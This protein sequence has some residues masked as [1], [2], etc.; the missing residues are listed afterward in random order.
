MLYY[1]IMNKKII[2]L[3]LVLVLFC[4]VLKRRNKEDF[5]INDFDNTVNTSVRVSGIPVFNGTKDMNSLKDM[6][7]SSNFNNLMEK[8][9]TYTVKDS[10]DQDA[11]WREYDGITTHNGNINLEPGIADGILTEK[12]GMIMKYIDDIN[13]LPQSSTEINFLS[14]DKT[15]TL[16][17]N[18]IDDLKEIVR[19]RDHEYKLYKLLFR[20]QYIPIECKDHKQRVDEQGNIVVDEDGEIV[21][22]PISTYDVMKDAVDINNF[23]L[24]DSSGKIRPNQIVTK[25]STDRVNYFGSVNGNTNALPR[26][27]IEVVD[28]FNSNENVKFHVALAVKE[29]YSNFA[30]GIDMDKKEAANIAILRCMYH[31][32]SIDDRGSAINTTNISITDKNHLLS[33]HP[34]LGSGLSA[35]EQNTVLDQSELENSFIQ[36]K[37]ESN[38]IGNKLLNEW[39]NLLEQDENGVMTWD[40]LNQSTLNGVRSLR[41]YFARLAL[42]EHMDEAADNEG[43]LRNRTELF[44]IDNE[45]VGLYH[46]F[47]YDDTTNTNCA[48]M[49]ELQNISTQCGNNNCFEAVVVGY[50][51]NSKQCKLYHESVQVDEKYKLEQGIGKSGVD[52][53]MYLQLLSNAKQNII[54][55]TLKQCIDENTDSSNRAHCVVKSIEFDNDNLPIQFQ[56]SMGYEN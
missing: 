20:P 49:Q 19:I 18:N 30:I 42:N 51:T 47:D 15:R 39:K 2:L 38:D 33:T 23:N 8:A 37:D 7:G 17:P 45:R 52:E 5:D 43:G 31:I 56:N 29:D 34:R 16:D 11:E 53:S 6:L 4:L 46:L 50:N 55:K 35:I 32:K 25:D 24:Y 9:C 40:K 44:M 28:F 48:D 21:L 54:D 41:V 10:S 12:P 36:A 14:S 13:K 22:D 1:N 3:L 27:Y 26:N